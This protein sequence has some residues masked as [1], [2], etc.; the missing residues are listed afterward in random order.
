MIEA[1]R[2]RNIRLIHVKLSVHFH[3]M[4]SSHPSTRVIHGGLADA[5]GKTPKLY[6]GVE[7]HSVER[8]VTIG[9]ARYHRTAN[10]P[11]SH[12]QGLCWSMWR[13]LQHPRHRSIP[14]T[15]VTQF[16]LGSRGRQFA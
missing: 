15:W 6:F 10:F 5:D 9:R 2:G 11:S 4:V 8:V 1:R 3:G 13:K 14:W 7:P 16:S 12:L